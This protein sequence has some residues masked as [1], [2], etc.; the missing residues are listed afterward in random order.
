MLHSGVFFNAPFKHVFGY[1]T[2]NKHLS[3]SLKWIIVNTQEDCIVIKL[4]IKTCRTPP[5]HT[6]QLNVPAGLRS[7]HS[8]SNSSCTV[9]SVSFR[10]CL[11]LAPDYEKLYVC[12][13]KQ[14]TSIQVINSSSIENY[15]NTN[16]NDKEVF[17]FSLRHNQTSL[18][19][20]VYVNFSILHCRREPGRTHIHDSSSREPRDH[21]SSTPQ[22]F[23][24]AP[25]RLRLESCWSLTTVCAPC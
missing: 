14:N 18:S 20:L 24:T 5:A 15:F 22:H 1:I 17:P 8:C 3:T 2:F 9:L 16:E 6:P 10:Q 23:G 19:L 13:P 25:R 4:I 7:T 11:L 21:H 12:T